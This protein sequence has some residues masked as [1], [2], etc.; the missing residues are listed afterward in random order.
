MIEGRGLP[1][2]P[3]D[4]QAQPE[5]DEQPPSV[6]DVP[7]PQLHLPAVG[8]EENR[9]YLFWSTDGFPPIVNGRAST[10]PD[11]IDGLIREMQEFPDAG[12]VQRL[13]EF[14]VRSVILHTDRADGWPQEGAESKP[15]EGLGL[16]KTRRGPLV[17]YRLD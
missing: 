8:G 4:K 5:V 6:V 3:S 15:I 13:R 1:F 10:R 17:I 9:R 14:G 2:D 11:T 7:A 12:T 16:A